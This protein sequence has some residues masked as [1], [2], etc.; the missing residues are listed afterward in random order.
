MHRAEL[1]YRPV[2]APRTVEERLSR[3]LVPGAIFDSGLERRIDRLEQRFRR[4]AAGYPHGLWAP[5]LVITNEMRG[6]T[7]LSLPLAE[8]QR[9]FECVFRRSLTFTPFLAASLIHGSACWLD[10]LQRLQPLVRQANPAVLLRLVTT[11]E[12]TRRR[13]LFFNFL[14]RQYGGGFCRYPGQTAFLRDWL[15][16]NRRRFAA[17][18]CCLDAACGSG[19]GTYELALLLLENGFRVD[20]FQVHGSTLEPFELFAAAHCCFPHEPWRQAAY[21]RRIEPL[22]QSGVADRMIFRQEDIVGAAAAD[23]FDVV[24]CNGILGGP[25]VH[26]RKALEMAIACLTARLKPGGMLLAADRFHDGWRKRTP[27]ALLREVFSD[28]GL[29]PLMVGEGVAGITAE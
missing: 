24:L 22:F 12:D 15:R 21:R 18:L 28:C 6:M 17:E 8:I 19:E 9:L 23:K 1:T 5:G 3:L 10:A 26:G 29:R 27:P 20:S 4:Y 14:P 2:L 16:E 7:E 11:D 25:F 13:F